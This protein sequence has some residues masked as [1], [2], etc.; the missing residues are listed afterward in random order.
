MR[1]I[2]LSDIHGNLHALSAVVDALPPHDQVF[3]AGDLCLEGPHPAEVWDRLEE[4][5]WPMVMGNT[6]RDIVS[7][8]ANAKAGKHGAVI[9]WTREQLGEERLRKLA[10][11]PFS[12]R[13]GQNDAVLVVHANPKNMD[14]HLYPTMSEE[15][16]TPYL[17]GVEAEVVVFGH[18]HIPYVRPVLGRLLVDVSSVGHPKDR[19]LRAAFTVIE[20][21]GESRS[22]TQVR[23]PYDLEATVRALRESGMPRAEKEIA[24]LRKASY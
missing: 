21:E 9:Q 5:G 13:G 12:L 24:S 15:E 8:P 11:L 22:V 1:S 16:L 7:T 20:W 10:S 18:L 17:A 23:V 19:D 14:Q 3:V 2:F 4:L 6:D